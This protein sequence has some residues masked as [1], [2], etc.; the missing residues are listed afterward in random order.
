M[1]LKIKDFEK[2]SLLSNRNLEKL[3]SSVINKSYNAVL[4][5]MYEDSVI[6]LDHNDGYFYKADY[7]FDEDTL[8]FV[9]DKFDRIILEKE[10][11]D[12]NKKVYDFFDGNSDSTSLIESYKENISEQDKVVSELINESL[13]N[14]NFEEVLDLSEIFES[15]V[16]VEFKNESWFK[17]WQ[18][19]NLTH[20]LME[21]YNFDWINPVSVSFTESEKVKVVSKNASERARNLWKNEKFK[22]VL[23]ESFSSLI[24]NVEEGIEKVKELLESYPIIF[25]LDKAERKTLFGKAVIADKDLREYI[26]DLNKGIDI[27]FESN[28]EV[29]EMKESYLREECSESKSKFTEKTE[30]EPKEEDVP[31]EIGKDENEKIA[32]KLQEIA[33]KVSDEKLKEKLQKIIDDLADAEDTGMKVESVKEAIAILSL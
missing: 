17:K 28:E 19:R 16:D 3:A 13:S 24:E 18:E 8:T 25:T 2:I 26:T 27:L 20:P 1:N 21:V 30:E 9:F 33:D 29:K 7:R 22:V 15:K 12:F 10:E 11:V 23:K 5:N 32:K 6:L 14:K 4:V 31:E